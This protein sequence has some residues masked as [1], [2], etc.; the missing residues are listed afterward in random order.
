M[1]EQSLSGY[2]YMYASLAREPP[3]YSRGLA[4]AV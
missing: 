3:T 2:V 4:R 1:Y